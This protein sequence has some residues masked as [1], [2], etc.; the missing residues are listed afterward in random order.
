MNGYVCLPFTKKIK[1]MNG[2][3]CL[4][5]TKKKKPYIVMVVLFAIQNLH[6]IFWNKRAVHIFRTGSSKSIKLAYIYSYKNIKFFKSHK[7]TKDILSQNV[8][9]DSKIVKIAHDYY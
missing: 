1:N 2:Y 5:L 4:P 6:E 7:L 9:N 3:V 8:H